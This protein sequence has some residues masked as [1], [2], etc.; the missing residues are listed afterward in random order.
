MTEGALTP[1]SPE[2]GEKKEMLMDGNQSRQEFDDDVETFDED[3]HVSSAFDE[4]GSEEELVLTD[5][6]YE[7]YAA[8]AKIV[9][10][11]WVDMPIRIGSISRD[12][13]KD[14]RMTVYHQTSP[15]ACK[16]IM[17][18]NFRLGKGG[19]CGK[20]IYFALTPNATRQKAVTESSGHGCMLEVVV[21]VGR[22]GRYK[23]CG[24]YNSMGLR[25]LNRAGYDTILFEPPEK[26]GDEV[27]IFEP[28]RVISKKIM[29][30][31]KSWM[32]KRWYGKPR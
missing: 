24:K 29:P 15:E 14:H 23:Q 21:D 27:I 16:G 6:A 26:T 12:I 10:A 8:A 4:D 11:D 13:P 17:R 19:W 31:E 5:D 32:A 25:K 2:V 9:S 30:F 7:K 1:A 28:W 22:I 3:G 20:G 18:S